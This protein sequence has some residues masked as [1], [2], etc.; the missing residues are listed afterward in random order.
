[1]NKK[2][3]EDSIETIHTTIGDLVEAI[4][5]LASESGKSENEGY[6]LAKLTVESILRRRDEEL[7]DLIQ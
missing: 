6:M 2:V 5:D 3:A 1:M 4:T 7:F